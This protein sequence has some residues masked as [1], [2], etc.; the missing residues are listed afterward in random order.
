MS[1][2]IKD[3]IETCRGTENEHFL[4][5]ARLLENHFDGI[6]NHARYKISTG[7][8]EGVNNLVK[9]ERRT[10]YG[11]PDDEYFFLRLMDASRKKS[12]F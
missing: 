5:F 6:V 3:I 8:V 4:W 12:R 2:K 10:G 9:T 11:Y 7:K 1:S